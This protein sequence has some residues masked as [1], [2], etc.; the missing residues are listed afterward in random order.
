MESYNKNILIIDDKIQ[1]LEDEVVQPLKR[2]GFFVEPQSN[3]ESGLK[4]ASHYYS[5][6]FID[7]Q[8][9]NSIKHT[10]TTL[11]F[12]IREDCPLSTIILLTAYGKENIGNFTHADW[13]GY[14]EKGKKGVK[15]SDL[16]TIIQEC[17][18]K[19]IEVRENKYPILKKIPTETK[20]IRDKK[21]ILDK[22]EELYE[23]KPIAKDWDH[24]AVALELGYNNRSALS[25]KFTTQ[26][27]E[28]K[29]LKKEALIFRHI[30]MTNPSQWLLAREHYK[31]L[32]ELESF[33]FGKGW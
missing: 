17:L 20:A 29:A 13:D 14:F 23:V 6:I 15:A 24:E 9:D 26:S 21:A 19:A 22:L 33:F 7:Y 12:K 28:T 1:E 4:L 32:S 27:K 3:P 8:F 25:Q 31:P 18:T 16:D 2:L 10:G 5:I 30:L 11:C